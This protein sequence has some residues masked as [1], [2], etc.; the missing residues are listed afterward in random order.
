[1]SPDQATESGLLIIHQLKTRTQ[2][3]AKQ[4]R[5]Q[6]QP[7]SQKSNQVDSFREQLRRVR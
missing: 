2:S 4:L 6:L 1:M 5:L 7:C 3:N